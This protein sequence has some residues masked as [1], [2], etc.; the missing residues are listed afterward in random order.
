MLCGKFQSLE[1]ARL[2]LLPT[3][4]ATRAQ[5]RPSTPRRVNSGGGRA[6]RHVHGGGRH[7]GGGR[8]AARR[9]RQLGLTLVRVVMVSVVRW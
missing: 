5:R 2:R 6:A 1:G 9:L 4:A 8:D 3:P 7:P